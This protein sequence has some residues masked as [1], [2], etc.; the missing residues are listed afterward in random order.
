MPKSIHRAE[1]KAVCRLLRQLRLEAKLKQADVAAALGKPQPF[2]SSIETGERRL[3]VIELRDLCGA[4]GIS[5]ATFCRLLEESLKTL[6]AV[7][8]P[9]KK[10]AEKA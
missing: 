2:I 4:L 5:L 10:R 6:K 1:Y 8:K 3:D 9:A 7:R